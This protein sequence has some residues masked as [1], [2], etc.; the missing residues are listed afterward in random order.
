MKVNY[1]ILTAIAALIALAAC[2]QQG[3][4]AAEQEPAVP[5]GTQVIGI[6]ASNFIVG[7]NM[8]APADDGT[9]LHF[10]L[11]E[12][13]HV[14]F[15][16]S[17][18][19]QSTE[20]AQYGP[21]PSKP[22]FTVRF[23]VPIP[24]AYSNGDNGQLVGLDD[25][26]FYHAHS[27]GF[28]VMDNGDAYAVYFSSKIGKSESDTSTAFYQARLRYGSEDWDMPELFFYTEGYNDQSA[29]LWKD[30]TEDGR[31]WFFG[32]GRYISDWVPFRQA[33]SD[34]NGETWT[35]SIP[36]L[37]APAQDYTAQPISSAFRDPAGNLY[38]YMDAD[39]SESVAWKSS[40]DGV[41]WTDMGG[42]TGGRH[43]TVVP[44]DDKGNL[45]SIGGKNASVDGWTPKNYSSDWGAT[46]TPSEPA[47][48]PQL[49]SA[50]RPSMI[51]LQSGKLLLVTDGY[52]LKYKVYP[53]EDWKYGFDAVVCI[54][55]DNGKTWRVKPLPVGLPHNNP[56]RKGNTSLGY[57]TV[58]QAPNGVIE[59][60][61]SANF[62]GLHYEFNEAWVLSDEGD[63]APETTGGEIKR[64]S[65]KYDNGRVKSRWSARICPGGRYLLDGKLT[66]YYPSGRRQHVATYINGRKTG[67][68][69]FWNPDGSKRWTWERD[70]ETNT[71]VW[72][73][74]WLNGKKKIVSHWDIN[75]VPRDL[76]RHFFGY[77][78]Q[79][80]AIHYDQKGNVT[81]TYTFDKG[82]IQKDE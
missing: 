13:D 66:D 72:T 35:F 39:G 44:L 15:A 9:P 62:P 59:V 57:S 54:S 26:V 45:L 1:S 3:Q 30:P 53:P 11:K 49:G 51:R 23:A 67:T 76:D 16:Q 36:K 48:F 78:A 18:V 2:G 37:T 20:P 12:R 58:R 8:D 61:T 55:D 74:Y 52:L 25:G 73:Q 65:E 82:L 14:P 43:S 77:V 10:V 22:Y 47:Y 29:L 46:W 17:A 27:P 64:F 24:A 81:A 4:P 50:Q 41:T 21:D 19:H 70:L 56:T 75:P 7:A 63:I 69:T 71:G 40:D 32:G 68:E 34:D 28:E 42:R 60:L 31:I 6:R 5:A 80:D 38:F 79:G 33:Y